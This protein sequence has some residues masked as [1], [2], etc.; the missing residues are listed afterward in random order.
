MSVPNIIYVRL[1]SIW[2][3]FFGHGKYLADGLNPFYKQHL[4]QYMKHINQPHEEDEYRN[5]QP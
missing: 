3:L 2:Y 4:K 5:I 1:T